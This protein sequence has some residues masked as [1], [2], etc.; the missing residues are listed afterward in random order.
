MKFRFGILTLA[1]DENNQGKIKENIK[2][3]LITVGFSGLLFIYCA[4]LLL[5]LNFTYYFHLSNS[6]II[7]LILFNDK[8][9]SDRLQFAIICLNLFNKL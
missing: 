1:I 8:A 2:K 9:F 4:V 6:P 3:T 7:S 5:N